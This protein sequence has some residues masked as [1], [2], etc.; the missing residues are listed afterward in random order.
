MR[1]G[2][3]FINLGL[4]VLVKDILDSHRS[5]GILTE[6]SRGEGLTQRDMG[7][8]VGMAAGLVNTYLKLLVSKG[9]VKISGIPPKRFK[10]YLTPK[11]FLEKSKLTYKLIQNYTSVFQEARGDYRLLFLNLKEKGVREVFF[12]GIDEVAEIAYLSLREAGME[13]AGAADDARA[14]ANFFGVRVSPFAELDLPDS[15]HV[16][17]TSL[18]NREEVHEVLTGRGIGPERVHGTHPS[19]GGRT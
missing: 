8:R 7:R 4:G 12:A 11:G 19:S 10:Y 15:A 14:G 6:I 1:A 9:Y 13:L 3:T 18:K 2:L 5:L 16:V 17:L